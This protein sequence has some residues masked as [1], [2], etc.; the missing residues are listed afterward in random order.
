[1]SWYYKLHEI[2]RVDLG[3]VLKSLLRWADL[4]C[5]YTVLVQA[6]SES[7]AEA[8]MN[9]LINDLVVYNAP[10]RGP[11]GDKVIAIQTAKKEFDVLMHQAKEAVLV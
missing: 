10:M 9:E 5:F 1:M 2:P 11:F 4:P 7:E 6:N 3:G 8:S